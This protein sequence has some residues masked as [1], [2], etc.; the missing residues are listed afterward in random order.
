MKSLLY[1]SFLSTILVLSASDKLQSQLNFADSLFN[2]EN[3]YQSITEYKRLQF[4]DIQ[5]EYAYETNFKIGAAYKK[6]GFYE[7][8]IEYLTKAKIEANFKQEI[9]DAEFQIVRTNI[10]RNTFDRALQ[11][12][13]EIEKKETRTD[14][15]NELD[16]WRGWTYMLWDKW[17]L[18]LQ[19]FSNISEDHELKKLCEQVENEKYS[20]TFAHVISY[21]LPG[22]GQFYTGNYFAGFMSAA[23]NVLWGYLTINSF[24]EDRAFDG[25]AIGSLLWLRFYR[26]NLQSAKKLAEEENITIANNAFIYLM[27]NYKGEKP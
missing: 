12:L 2:T 27:E 19:C 26:G 13:D 16:Y 7:K 4:F 22:A 8:A 11:L 6:G 14:F 10:L 9:F 5:N 24:L 25:A 1:I 21:I 18:A 17:D 20:V 15:Q 23:W 3:Y